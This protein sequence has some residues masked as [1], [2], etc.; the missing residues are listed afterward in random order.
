MT[1]IG[2]LRV[3]T[4]NG[5][6]LGCLAALC[7]LLA[8]QGAAVAQDKPVLVFAAASLKNALD[9]I[10]DALA[11]RDRQE[12]DD[13]LR[14]QLGARAPDRA[15]RAGR[16]LHLRRSRLDGLSRRARPD[17][18]R[19]RASTCSATASC[20]S[21]RRT[22]LG[23]DDR[24]GL[25]PCRALL[26]DGRLAMANV[27]AVPAGKYGKAALEA[28]GVWACGRRTESRR[29]TMCA[30]PWCWSR[31][32]RRRSASSTRPT[33]RP[34]RACASSALFPEDYPSADHLS[35]RGAAPV[36]AIRTPNSSR[37]SCARPRRAASSRWH[38]FT[39]LELSLYD[40]AM[41][42]TLTPEEWTAVRLS[43]RVALW[44]TLA[45]LP[46]GLAGGA[47]C[48]RAVGSGASR[49]STC[50]CICR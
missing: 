32:A 36:R 7:L 24:A 27:D 26:G 18:R 4:R 33:P 2:R 42:G 12:G 28:L 6:R 20:W 41:T 35:G 19:A 13:L 1:R 10:A 44:A 47:R 43:L 39:V 34:S 17:P 25:R 9:D 46:L 31:A 50:W 22:R 15:G 11:T 38:G 23:S 40:W 16:R 48:W 5:A 30:R 21:R 49:C 37:I 14:R 8:S 3:L 29:P 45:S